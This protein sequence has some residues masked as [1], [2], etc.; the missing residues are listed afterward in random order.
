MLIADVIYLKGFESFSATKAIFFIYNNKITHSNLV[1]SKY[2]GN[3]SKTN[4]VIISI[5]N[6]EK[7]KKQFTGTLSFYNMLQ[8]IKL[9]NDFENGILKKN[10]IAHPKSKKNN[11]SNGCTDW[12][13]VTTYSDGSQKW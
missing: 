7:N 10:S 11:K 8:N 2:D 4:Q 9:T 3:F 12:Y 6:M 5:L 1:T 13:W